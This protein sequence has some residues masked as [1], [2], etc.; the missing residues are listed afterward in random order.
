ME[1]RI[2]TG[3]RWLESG[4]TFDVNEP[5]SGAHLAEVYA[6]DKQI[7]SDSIAAAVEGSRK[8]ARLPRFAIARGLR[9]IA[10]GIA[11]RR[12]EFASMIARESAKP[13]VYARGEVERG[14][15][16]FAWAAGEAERFIGEIVP[17][18]TQAGGMGKSAYT[19]QKPRGVIYGIT[20]F[21]FP[22]NLV[23]HKV[24][25]ALA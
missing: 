11:S 20:P 6:A 18:D 19:I 24:A 4:T 1:R 15:A 12:E 16:T 9:R 17:V 21:N 3:G 22:L 13:L 10:D 7:S 25:P 8:M 5:Y 14:I 23:A 2:L